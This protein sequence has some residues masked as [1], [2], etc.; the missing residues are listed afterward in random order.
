[1]RHLVVACP[2]FVADNL[3]TLEEMGIQGRETFL[4][5][6]GEHFTLAPCL[7][8]APAWVEALAAGLAPYTSSA[9]SDTAA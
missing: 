4:G 2:A 3:E 7:N 1:M 9:N 6:G 8:D 5:A